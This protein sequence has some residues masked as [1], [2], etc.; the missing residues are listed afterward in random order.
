[1]RK[2]IISNISTYKSIAEEAHQKMRDASSIYDTDRNSFKQAMIAIVFTGMWLEALLH[3]LIVR[4]HGEETFKEYDYKTYEE[5]LQLLGCLDLHIIDCAKRFRKAR[6][7]LVH[8]KAHF[9]NSEFTA[10]Q[11]EADN[12][13]VL[14][15]T[16]HSKFLTNKN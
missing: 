13:Y 5:K 12:A 7:E 4:K 11:D 3:L 2:F 15:N 16:L 10:A 8:E 14:L 6:K 1:M 9:D